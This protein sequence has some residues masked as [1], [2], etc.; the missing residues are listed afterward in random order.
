MSNLYIGLMSG[1]SLDAVDAVLV[2]FGKQS[3]Q[4]ITT[5]QHAIPIDLRQEI[6]DLN[7]PSE[8][9]IHRM[10]KAD[11]KLGHLFAESVLAL[12]EK[13]NHSTKDINAIG[14]HGQN[15]HHA[16]NAEYPFTLQIGDPNIIAM[17]TGI[18]TVADFRRRD[19]ALGG[20]AAP[21][22]PAFHDYL[23]QNRSENIGVLNI[24]GIA[25]LTVLPTKPSNNVIGFDTGP[26]NTLMDVWYQ[27]QHTEYYDKNGS[28]AA[29]GQYNENLLMQLLQDAY[30]SKM[31]PKSTGR[32]YFHWNWLMPHLPTSIKPEDLQ[33]TLM[34]L[35]VH[36]I[37]NA[38]N[39]YLTRN[40]RLYVCGGGT[41]NT[42]LMHRLKEYCECTIQ[43]IET[44]GIH[45]DWVEAAAF[46]WLARQTLLGKPG[47]IPSV[48]GASAPSI[49]GAIYLANQ[50]SF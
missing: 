13:T 14:S 25:N 19:M 43:S 47:N 11:V 48:T 30:F 29:S 26:G 8:N 39:A 17:K 35:T 38:V 9:T 6:L 31:P 41:H 33:A 23:F 18:N 40:N 37:S 5:H 42:A 34:E 20:Q 4:V 12:L 46:A 15:I 3:T 49:L 32:E 45:P 27:K 22:A 1:T 16:P 28:W 7:Q 50:S 2:E 36:S 44:V 10:G 24:G 21:L